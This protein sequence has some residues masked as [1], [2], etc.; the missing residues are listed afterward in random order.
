MF[1]ATILHRV[2]MILSGS[3][4]HLANLNIIA[5]FNSIAVGLNWVEST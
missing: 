1:M 3:W 2:A 5:F 4:R